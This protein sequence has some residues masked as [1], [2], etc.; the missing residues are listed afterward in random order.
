[1]NTLHRLK[2][3]AW[4]A[5]KTFQ[6]CGE[7][8]IHSSTKIIFTLPPVHKHETMET[9]MVLIKNS[10]KLTWI[11]WCQQVRIF[12][13]NLQC[14]YTFHSSLTYMSVSLHTTGPLLFVGCLLVV[15]RLLFV[16]LFVSLFVC[17]LV[18]WW[19]GWSVGRSVGC[20]RRLFCVFCCIH[21]HLCF[22]FPGDSKSIF[23]L[24]FSWS[25]L[26]AHCFYFK[27]LSQISQ[28]SKPSNI[29]ISCSL[30]GWIG[31]TGDTGLFWDSIVKSCC[32]LMTSDDYQYQPMW[33]KL[34]D[35]NFS[36][37][38]MPRP[39][40]GVSTCDL[41]LTIAVVEHKQRLPPGCSVAVWTS[42]HC[43]VFERGTLVTKMY[44]VNGTFPEPWNTCQ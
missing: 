31:K 22:G 42:C 36:R 16:Y 23:S 39:P 11:L 33:F 13:W 20:R 32:I 26:A 27:F 1:M 7:M 35:G 28:S 19:V 8:T 25:Q 15:G 34:F 21:V 5:L 40:F 18:G 9:C 2:E 3:N 6:T 17:W 38:S 10:N 12:C 14:F 41:T 24:L 29:P 44:E 37:Q 43:E 30:M 4:R